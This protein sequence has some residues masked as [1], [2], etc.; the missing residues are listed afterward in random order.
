[1]GNVNAAVA[2]TQAIDIWN[3]QYVI[4][5]GI[6]GGVKKDSSRILGDVIVAEQMSDTS[7][8]AFRKQ[9]VTRRYDVLRPAHALLEAARNLPPE[10]WLC[11]CRSLALTIRLV[12]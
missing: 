3:P 11:L 2:T 7:K 1:M 5:C 4:V 8:A 10:S 12:E 6:A 9:V